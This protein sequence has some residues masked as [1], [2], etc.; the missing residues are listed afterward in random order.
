QGNHSL[1]KGLLRNTTHGEEL[2]VAFLH[3]KDWNHQTV[4]W[5]DPAGKAALFAGN[6]TAPQPHIQ[7]LLDKGISVVGVDLLYQGEFLPDDKPVTQTRRVDNTREAAAYT[8]GYNHTLFAQRVHDILT[9]IRFVQT[10][11]RV[12][13]TLGLAGLAGA[14]PWVA[15]ACAVA[16]S[17]VQD[18]VV[19]TGGFRFVNVTDIRDVHFLPG[20]AKY[21]DLPGMLALAAPGRLW[22]AGEGSR[23]PDLVLNLYKQSKATRRLATFDGD[24]GQMK[25]AAVRWLIGSRT[26]R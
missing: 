8:F 7:Q 11:E 22:L 12:T 1:M 2:P 24:A 10:N 20:G 5:I 16:G 3:P 6:G 14:G 18:I 21:G 17:A 23:A 25:D 9:V 26:A 13:E 4:I 15:A 19:D